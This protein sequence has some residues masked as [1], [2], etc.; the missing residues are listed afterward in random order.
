MPKGNKNWT[1][2]IY[3]ESCI[4]AWD[5]A[6][7]FMRYRGFI[8][9]Y[10]DKDVNDNG[11]IKKPHYH[12]IIQLSSAR[13]NDKYIV[14][15][16]M[17]KIYLPD[18]LLNHAE[19]VSDMVSQ[20][21]YLVHADDPDKYQYNKEDI[22]CMGGTSID[23]YFKPVYNSTIIDNVENI[24]MHNRNEIT[25][26]GQLLHFLKF[27]HLQDELECVRSK[28]LYFNLLLKENCILHSQLQ[29]H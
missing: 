14:N 28:Y 29:N 10:H 25:T 12:V 19:P 22:I 21:R 13:P 27:N 20:V 3:P 2:I 26:M 8:S 15:Q 4:S 11:E 24:I 5:T 1:F 17:R 6:L 16:I 18:K 9:P 23:K 7:I